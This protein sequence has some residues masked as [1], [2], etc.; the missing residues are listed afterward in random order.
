MFQ[1]EIVWVDDRNVVQ[2]KLVTGASKGEVEAVAC[3]L[4]DTLGLALRYRG[5]AEVVA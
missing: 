2:V 5:A 1:I 3:A 4:A